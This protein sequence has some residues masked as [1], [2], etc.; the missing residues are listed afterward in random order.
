MVEVPEPTVADIAARFK[1]GDKIRWVGSRSK[2]RPGHKGEGKFEGTLGDKVLVR[3]TVSAG[4]QDKTVPIAP[5]QVLLDEPQ[6]FPL[7]DAG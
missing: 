2:K 6:P 7:A 3:Y 1:R 5:W 4:Y